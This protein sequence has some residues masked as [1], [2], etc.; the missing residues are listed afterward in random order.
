MEDKMKMSKKKK[1]HLVSKNTSVVDIQK[2][3]ILN[4]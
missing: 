1:Q 4:G 3:D 2:N